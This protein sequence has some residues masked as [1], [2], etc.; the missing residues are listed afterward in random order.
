L[1]LKV[2]IILTEIDLCGR[3]M[4]NYVRIVIM[5]IAQLIDLLKTFPLDADVFLGSYMLLDSDKNPGV[6]VDRPIKAVAHD[7][8][9][10]KVRFVLDGSDEELARSMEESFRKIDG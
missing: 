3:L 2:K 6:V 1:D 5:K 9:A 10:G 8:N 4:N 7:T